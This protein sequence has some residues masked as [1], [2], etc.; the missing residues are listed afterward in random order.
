M[1]LVGPR[2]MMPEQQELYPGKAYFSLRPGLTGPWQV[3]DRNASSFASRAEFDT[4][5]ANN[6]TLKNDLSILYSTVGLL[7]RA[8]GC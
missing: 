4:C 6:L 1:S 7:F 3:S 2:P 8:T 5:Y